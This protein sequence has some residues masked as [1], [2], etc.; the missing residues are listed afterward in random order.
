MKIYSFILTCL[1]FV[2]PP[3][4]SK[5]FNSDYKDALEFT[6]QNKELINKACELH[7]S[8]TALITSVLFPELI[9]YSLLKDF[10]ETKALEMV[11]V[12]YGSEYVDF[13]IGRFQM[14]PSFIEKMEKYIEN[15]ELLKNKLRFIYIYDSANT[16]GIRKQRVERLKSI[17]WQLHYANCFYSIVSQ[18][19][20]NIKWK[21]KTEKI[22]F[23]ATAYNHGFNKTEEEI[24]H[25]IDIKV[26]PYGTN[27]KA[28]QYAYS[29]IA[30]DFYINYYNI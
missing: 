28:N 5:V 23:Y 20:K 10:F 15:N 26:F 4:H 12:N 13:S 14:K 27:Y 9:R 8:D 2:S 19:F 7:N 11:Y 24:K 30:V 29:D 16:Q 22:R 17:V 25:W 18:K 1:L 6:R 3:D 21:N